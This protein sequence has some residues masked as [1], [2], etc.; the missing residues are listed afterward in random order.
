MSGFS[1]IMQRCDDN[2]PVSSALT[3]DLQV[4][5]VGE[6]AVAGGVGG[7]FR[8]FLRLQFFDSGG[9]GIIADAQSGSG[10]LDINDGVLLQ[11]IKYSP[12][13]LKQHT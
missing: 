2:L 4:C 12:H 1:F 6:N 5:L 10:S 7:F 3:K 11:K 13:I 8:D 9:G